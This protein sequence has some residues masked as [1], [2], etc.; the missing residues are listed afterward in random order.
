MGD[1]TTTIRQ[2]R[3]LKD[4]VNWA[5][6]ALALLTGAGGVKAG[7]DVAGK[8]ENVNIT[9][10]EIKGAIQRGDEGRVRLE[11]RMEKVEERVRALEIGRKQ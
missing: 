5:A 9:L 3:S 8:L 6:I 7:S 1:E 10:A 11:S 2:G 4:H